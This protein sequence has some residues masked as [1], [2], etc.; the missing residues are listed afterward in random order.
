MKK[1]K[2]RFKN[3]LQ[4]EFFTLYIARIWQYIVY[5]KFFNAPRYH[6]TIAAKK[7]IKKS[8]HFKKS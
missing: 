8:N 2:K 5:N 4:F 1:K 6:K 3:Y 7:F